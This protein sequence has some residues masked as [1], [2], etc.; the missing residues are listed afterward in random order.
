M[1]AL[2]ALH[3]SLHGDAATCA[4]GIIVSQALLA[5]GSLAGSSSSVEHESWHAFHDCLVC[6]TQ[7][8]NC[9]CTSG[10]SEVCASLKWHSSWQ[11]P[12]M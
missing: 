1:A 6:H 12:P 3:L 2:M 4:N 10:G 7:D 11:D 8:P 9:F 5:F